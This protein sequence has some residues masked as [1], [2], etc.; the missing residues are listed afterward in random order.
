MTSLYDLCCWVAIKIKYSNCF[1][2]CFRV[3]LRAA[4]VTGLPLTSADSSCP[5]PRPSSCPYPSPF[6]FPY[7]SPCPCLCPSRIRP[8][9]AVIFCSFACD[10]LLS[11]CS[12]SHLT[13]IDEHVC[14]CNYDQACCF[15]NVLSVEVC[16]SERRSELVEENKNKTK[17]EK[18]QNK[19]KIICCFCLP[20]PPAR[21]GQT[22][23]LDLYCYNS[24]IISGRT[25]NAC[26]V[27]GSGGFTM[28]IPAE[29]ACLFSN[30]LFSTLAPDPFGGP[31]GALGTRG[32]CTLVFGDFLDARNFP[33][34]PQEPLGLLEITETAECTFNVLTFDVCLSMNPSGDPGEPLGAM[35]GDGDR[36]PTCNAGGVDIVT[37]IEK[38]ELALSLPPCGSS[39]AGGGGGGALVVVRAPL[40]FVSFASCFCL[41]ACVPVCACVVCL[42]ACP[43]LCVCVRACQSVCQ[44]PCGRL[45]VCQCVRPCLCW[46]V[47]RS[48]C[49]CLCWPV[50]QSGCLCLFTCLPWLVGQCT[51]QFVRQCHS[52]CMCLCQ[53]TCQC[54]SRC[55]CL[56]QRTCQ[57]L[58]ESVC[59]Y[60]C[61]CVCQ[62]VCQSICQSVCQSPCLCVSV[63][64]SS[65]P[66]GCVC[67]L[68]FAS[69]LCPCFSLS[70]SLS[71]F[72]PHWLKP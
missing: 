26:V 6:P 63:C 24:R 9:P 25:L 11:G 50:G 42:C 52:Q 71:L 13:C 10:D 56:C 18:S 33:L 20:G 30:F 68:C 7:P 19:T 61:P 55:M 70:L 40:S 14:A 3:R 16:R 28:T 58:C 37:E 43:C 39:A 47:G 31:W 51:C 4:K 41:F 15:C 45:Y 21:P 46:P 27:F 17:I 38:L 49:H 48:F 23:L 64:W 5:C 72:F 29:A 36:R 66:C 54:L 2:F 67:L 60:V 69:F 1:D 35:G 8:S 44:S 57:C 53:C 12:A 34:G 22:P 65:C 32:L 62:Y 59:Q